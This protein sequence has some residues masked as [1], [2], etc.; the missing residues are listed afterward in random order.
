[1]CIK[2]K[3]CQNK[4]KRRRKK[5]KRWRRKKREEKTLVNQVKT[6]SSHPIYTYTFISSSNHYISVRTENKRREWENT[7][8]HAKT[9]E[10][11]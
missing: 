11:F 7:H 5:N 8:T 1:M 9:F 6:K 4:N 10:S 3:H 2:T